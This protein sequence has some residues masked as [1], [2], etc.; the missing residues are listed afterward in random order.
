MPDFTFKQYQSEA[1]GTSDYPDIFVG[2]KGKDIINQANYIYAALG[3]AGEA[4]E[5]VE[6]IKKIVRN[7]TGVTNVSDIEELKKELGDVLWYISDISTTLD[8]DLDEVA[9]LN[10]KKVKDRKERGVIRSKGDYR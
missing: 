4:G 1:A 8:I 6:K 5:V 10:I 3:L 2:D 9:K 7:K